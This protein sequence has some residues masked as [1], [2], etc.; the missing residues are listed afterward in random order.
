MA[1]P[2][3]SGSGMFA[4]GLAAQSWLSLLQPSSADI[5]GMKRS[6]MLSR[7]KLPRTVRLEHKGLDCS[8]TTMHKK[9]LPNY[10]I[11]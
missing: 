9:N 7:N 4:G 6:H 1:L 8:Y 5:R 2:G 10:T 11:L 3:A